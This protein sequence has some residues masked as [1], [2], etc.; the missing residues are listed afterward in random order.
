MVSCQ[1]KKKFAFIVEN[2]LKVS[3]RP[4]VVVF[5]IVHKDLDPN[6]WDILYI[7]NTPLTGVDLLL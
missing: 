7:L 6:R 4:L 2:F 3:V 5:G 1:R